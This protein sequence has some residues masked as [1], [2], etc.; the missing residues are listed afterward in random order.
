MQHVLHC[1]TCCWYDGHIDTFL[2]DYKASCRINSHHQKFA[3]GD[4]TAR[5]DVKTNDEVGELARAFNELAKN[6]ESK[7]YE[8]QM[9]AKKQEDF[10]ANF[11][12][13]LKTP[14]TS[15][16]GY[17]DTLY[18]KKCPRMRCTVLPESY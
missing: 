9:A 11:A 12:H 14:M 16:I 15:I 2:D 6:L 1:Y 7:V 13:E 10:T 3:D 5:S 8:L 17:A 4:Y 18:Q